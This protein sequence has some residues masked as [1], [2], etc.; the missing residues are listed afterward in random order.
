[1]KIKFGR[2]FDKTWYGA[3]RASHGKNRTIWVCSHKHRSPK[4]AIACALYQLGIAE[5]TMIRL[6]SRQSTGDRGK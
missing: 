3:I 5:R 1:M 2:R 6:W 4:T